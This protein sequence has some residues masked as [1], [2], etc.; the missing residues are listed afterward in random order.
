[1]HAEKT[2]RTSLCASL[3]GMSKAVAPA[4]TEERPDL[5]GVRRLDSQEQH[6]DEDEQTDQGSVEQLHHSSLGG[7]HPVLTTASVIES[8]IYL[9]KHRA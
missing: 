5:T 9:N 8:R 1:V 4:E 6:D 7:V 2:G 3:E